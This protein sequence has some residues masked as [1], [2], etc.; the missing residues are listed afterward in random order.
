VVL[1]CLF[2]GTWKTD[3]SIR[4]YGHCHPPVDESERLGMSRMALIVLTATSEQKKKVCPASYP[5][6]HGS[7]NGRHVP[8]QSHA[9]GS[10][11]PRSCTYS[12]HLLPA[13]SSIAG[14]LS[15]LEDLS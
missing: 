11:V 7:Y 4:F 3:V 12:Y 2:R 8:S 1:E 5:V 15:R 14:R 9:Y 13:P 10:S 6:C